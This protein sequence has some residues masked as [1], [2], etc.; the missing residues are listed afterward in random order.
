MALGKGTGLSS[1]TFLRKLAPDSGLERPLEILLVSSVFST[2]CNMH[3]TKNSVLVSPGQHL[4]S[5]WQTKF[6]YM[7]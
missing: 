7:N 3:N 5:H 6:K 2:F 4:V 1:D